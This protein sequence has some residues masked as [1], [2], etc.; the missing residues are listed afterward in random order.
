MAGCTPNTDNDSFL[1]PVFL[2]I[3]HYYVSLV[4]YVSSFGFLVSLVSLSRL[5]LL[6]LSLFSF[7]LSFLCCAGHTLDA[8][9]T[10]PIA[11]CL[12]S[13]CNSLSSLILRV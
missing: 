13:H 10:L 9:D 3:Y 2:S 1:F 12:G 8:Y 11:H 5:S 4:N 7:F 6:F